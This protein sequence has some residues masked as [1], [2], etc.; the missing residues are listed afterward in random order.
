MN[1]HE[2]QY[3]EQE[4]LEKATNLILERDFAR[5]RLTRK[6]KTATCDLKIRNCE[7]TGDDTNPFG[8]WKAYWHEV[9]DKDFPKKGKCPKCGKVAELEGAHV[10]IG[11]D[12]T[13]YYIIPMC[14]DCNIEDHKL[15]CPE[16]EY[17]MAWVDYSV[18]TKGAL[19]L[20]YDKK[21]QNAGAKKQ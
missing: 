3:S 1:Y 12:D 13:Q 18:A 17:E 16:C 5:E 19:H 7:A 10:W 20:K 11:S 21:R 14:H 8:A 15:F 2:Y 6:V 4:K 9:L